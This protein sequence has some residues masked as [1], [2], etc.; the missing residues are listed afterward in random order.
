MEPP[1]PSSCDCLRPVLGRCEYDGRQVGVDMTNCRYGEVWRHTCDRCGRIWLFYRVEY[2][3]FTASGRWYRAVISR[4]TADAVTPETAADAI[5][6][7]DYRI[8]GGSYFNS[9]GEIDAGPEPVLVDNVGSPSWLDRRG[10][11]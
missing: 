3:A 6:R 9:P 11:A 2:E 8:R 10:T 4:E 5:A 1:T 7:S